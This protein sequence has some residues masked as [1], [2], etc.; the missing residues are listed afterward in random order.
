MRCKMAKTRMLTQDTCQ[1]RNDET[2]GDMVV[3]TAIEKSKQ[4]KTTSRDLD[5]ENSFAAFRKLVER[6]EGQ[7]RD[8]EVLLSIME[9]MFEH[10]RSIPG[11]A[12]L[13]ALPYSEYLKTD[14]WAKK[15]AE[16]LFEASHRCSLCN[17]DGELHCHHR[18]YKRLGFEAR[19]DVICLCKD[20]HKVFHE[21]RNAEMQRH[22]ASA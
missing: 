18:T 13:L 5:K 14:H 22:T 7:E 4:P 19:G 6:M 2:F 9:R 20:C 8:K 3:R 12:L 11:N 21:N 17:A 15:R 16:A 1:N 10:E